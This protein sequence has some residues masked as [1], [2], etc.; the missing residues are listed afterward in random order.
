MTAPGRVP[1]NLDRG[2]QGPAVALGGSV[3]DEMI[4]GDHVLHFMDR[5]EFGHP[6]VDAGLVGAFMIEPPYRPSE[7]PG[8]GPNWGATAH[9]FGGRPWG[10]GS[11][12]S[13]E[14]ELPHIVRPYLR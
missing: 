13:V 8:T 4:A 14:A 12:V 7:R 9:S 11:C 5:G 6:A 3:D 1:D 2:E 10:S